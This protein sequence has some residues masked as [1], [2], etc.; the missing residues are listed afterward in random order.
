MSHLDLKRATTVGVEDLVLLPKIDNKNIMENLKLR[1]SKDLIYTSIGQVLISVN[2]FK[3]LPI[4]TDDL[5]QY[6]K[7]NGK[8]SSTPHVFAL[9]EDTY[10]TM[11]SEEENQCVIISGESGA[12]KTEASKQIMQYIAAV[13]GNSKDM[14]RV[15]EIMLESNPLLESFG[16]AKTVRNDNSSRFGKFFEIY[17]DRVGGP[18]GGKMSNFLLEKSRVVSQQRGERNFHIF[19]QFCTDS[20]MVAKYK[21]KPAAEFKYLNGGQ[22]LHREGV[23][24]AEE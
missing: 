3:R 13:S 11:I 10:R 16:N 12:G 21:L 8:T 7:A 6:Y 23:S 19:Y 15:K 14:E 2:P 24:D 4:Y 1:H 18:V 9:A 22:T 20:Q 5:I 17:F